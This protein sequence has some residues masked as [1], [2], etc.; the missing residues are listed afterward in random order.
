MFIHDVQVDL[1]SYEYVIIRD[2][3]PQWFARL[4]ILLMEENDA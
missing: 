2:H 1:V 4:V 3:E